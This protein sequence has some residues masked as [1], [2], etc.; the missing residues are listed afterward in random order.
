[1]V[2]QMLNVCFRSDS[3]SVISAFQTGNVPWWVSTRWNKVK[4]ELLS[5]YFLHSFREINTSADL[6]AKKGS[7][8]DKGDRR[9]YRRYP[10]F[11]TKLESP[12][13]PYYIFS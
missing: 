8:L 7:G 11:I 13:V 5:W 12:D 4:S 2:H 9:I 10:N 6:L 1:M 3:K